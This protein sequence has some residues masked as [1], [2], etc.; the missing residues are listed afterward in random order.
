MIEL[1]KEEINKIYYEACDYFKRNHPELICTV[2]QNVFVAQLNWQDVTYFNGRGLTKEA[3]TYRCVV[4]VFPNR[5]FYMI[6]VNTD[7]VDKIGLGGVKISRGAFA[8]R[9]WSYHFEVVLGQDNKTGE[10]GLLTYR[11]KS[12]EI[13]KPVKNYF[14]SLGLKSK[15]FSY[16]LSVKALPKAM[17]IVAI[18]VPLL[19][20]IVFTTIGILVLNDDFLFNLIFTG[21]GIIYLL[22]GIINLY[23]VLKKDHDFD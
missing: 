13:Q 16:S 6:D 21:M 22:W 12:S 8:G 4:K 23:F 14:K 3:R 1:T 7:N 15:F 20:G 9:S 19:C 5:T 10:T 17:Q 18:V 11:F 2:E